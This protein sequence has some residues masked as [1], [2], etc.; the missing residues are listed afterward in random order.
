MK[1]NLRGSEIV[2]EFESA[3]IFPRLP[4]SHLPLKNPTLEFIKT[5]S[6][7]IGLDEQTK[8]ESLLLRTTLLKMI[9]VL[10]FSPE[11]Q[12]IDPCQTLVLTDVIC[13]F[14]NQARDFDMCRDPL[15]LQR[16][17]SCIV[18]GHEFKV[19]QI[20]SLLIHKL[21]REIASYQV[22]DLKCKLCKSMQMENLNEFCRCAGS[23]E[24]TIS[25][26]R[27]KKS[28]YLFANIAEYYELSHLNGISQIF[29][30]RVSDRS[31]S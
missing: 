8:S 29:Y 3:D 26:G 19:D 4:G 5:V 25:E 14:C 7:V 9:G 30:P 17:W 27:M 23:F 18:C 28:M 1:V 11:A 31:E 24:P 6:H 13:T 22:Q 20:E 16:D 15:L 10:P 12:F 21:Q 2:G